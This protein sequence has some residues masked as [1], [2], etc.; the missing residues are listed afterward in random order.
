MI[1]VIGEPGIGKSRLCY[2]FISSL[3]PTDWLILESRSSSYAKT[4]AWLPVVYMLKAYF[5]IEDHDS[6]RQTEDKLTRR[7][8]A[9]DH[10][11][12]GD[13]PCFLTLLDMPVDDHDWKSLDP[14]LRRRRI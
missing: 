8:L 6:A 10:A 3:T 2:E 9:L 5:G 12:K 11:L 4:T 1:A 7:L 14:A 13:L